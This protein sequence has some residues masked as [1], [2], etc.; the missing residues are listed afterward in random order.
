MDKLEMDLTFLQEFESGFNPRAPERSVLPA[1]VLGYGEISTVLEISTE[2]M[3][4]FA[5]KRMPMF[6]N[7]TEVE[8]YLRVYEEY[9]RVMENQIGLNLVPSKTAWVR[10]PKSGMVILYILQEKMPSGT[11]GHQAIHHLPD[12]EVLK[13][14]QA[15]L[16]EMKK[17]FDF[18]R[19]HQGELELGLD[20][21]ISN[22][23]ILD[24]DPQNPQL[25]D[26]VRLAYFDTST[27]L[28][29]KDGQ[30]QLDPELFLRS[31]PSFLVWILR[32]FFLEDV[33]T[34]YYDFRRVIVDLIANFYKEQRPGL[35]PDLIDIANDLLS[36]EDSESEFAPIT[37]QEIRSY[38]REDAMIWRLYLSFRKVD[39][40]L[41]KLLSQDYPYVL[42]GKIQR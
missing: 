29:Q 32:L 21:Q 10:E 11:I 34:R 8:N 13:L 20:G 12:R 39:R 16:R 35:I 19:V 25:V 30:E 4:H 37:I 23:S 26:P 40:A 3:R 17:V 38:Y 7:E 2:N 27:P 33:L 14:V 28:M 41:H 6:R 15:V 31:A 5:C 42:P 36:T 1:H 22:W 24:Y 18:N 9:L